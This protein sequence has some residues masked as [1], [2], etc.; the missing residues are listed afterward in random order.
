MAYLRQSGLDRHI[1]EWATGGK[2]LL[3]ICLGTQIIFAHSEE[4]D[5]D[6]LGL[7]PGFVRRFPPP[8]TACGRLLKVPHMGWNEVAFRP[9]P[10]FANLPAGAQFYFVH[11]YYPVPQEE[12]WIV[13][14]TDYGIR[15]CAA[16]AHGNIVAVQFHPEKSGR[17]GLAI[18]ENFCRWD[19]SN[20]E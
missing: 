5:T 10:L 14:E 4:D 12:S 17:L 20:A 6:C 13:G 3:G 7:V 19:G 11:S 16:L 9:H 18:L 1:R 2:L 8:L 15:F